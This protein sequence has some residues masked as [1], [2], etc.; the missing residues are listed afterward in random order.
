MEC[1]GDA[2]AFC[3]D[4]LVWHVLGLASYFGDVHEFVVHTVVEH[5][6]LDGYGAVNI[7]PHGELDGLFTHFTGFTGV[8][9]RNYSHKGALEVAEGVRPDP[10]DTQAIADRVGE[11]VTQGTRAGKLDV[12]VGVTLFLA[13]QLGDHRSAFCI[14]DSFGNGDGDEA[15]LLVN[16]VHIRQELVRIKGTLRQV[17]EVRTVIHILTGQ[18][19]GCGEEACM[20]AHYNADIDAAQR[21]VVQIHSSECLAD[22]ASGRAEAR[23][24]VVLLKVIVDGLRNVDG[25]QV[26]VR[27]FCLLVHD[28]D[29]VRGIVTADVEEI[30]DVVGLHDL[31]H[32]GAV[33]FIRFITSGK[34]ARGRSAC[35]LLQVVGRFAGQIDEVF[36]NDAAY[37]VNR[38]ID[39]GHL[40]ELAGFESNADDA[41]VD[42]RG[43]AT[44]LGDKNF[45]D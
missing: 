2:V 22:E 43:W 19:G 13:E 7:V 41:L 34:E 5:R 10:L 32:A 45:S 20:T 44:T 37:A 12:A 39:G 8:A 28:A 26:V 31:E 3:V 15:V 18:C 21:T 25:A 40:A 33:F 36:V 9:V 16:A 23:A 35:H 27:S 4:E 29:G 38:S 14:G 17:N 24:V 11:Q 30:A 6:A 1:L 42:H